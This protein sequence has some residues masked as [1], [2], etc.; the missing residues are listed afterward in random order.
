MNDVNCLMRAEKIVNMIA[1]EGK[2]KAEPELK[3]I[4]EHIVEK[5]TESGWPR[6]NREYKDE[7]SAW[8]KYL[9]LLQAAAGKE[10]NKEIE[11]AKEDAEVIF[12]QARVVEEQRVL[13][14]YGDDIFKEK[15]FEILWGVQT[16]RASA[17]IQE[18]LQQL[19]EEIKGLMDE[20]D[21]A[22]ADRDVRLLRTRQ[23]LWIRANLMLA[24]AS[25]KKENAYEP[26]KSA[27]LLKDF[28]EEIDQH[29]K[30]YNWPQGRKEPAD[31]ERELT[32]G[33]V[34]PYSGE[35][36]EAGKIRDRISQLEQEIGALRSSRGFQM[37][38]IENKDIRGAWQKIND[39]WGQDGI[40]PMS[41]E[42]PD[43]SKAIKRCW[44][45]RNGGKVFVQEDKGRSTAYE[46]FNLYSSDDNKIIYMIIDDKGEAEGKRISGRY[47]KE[48][49]KT[50]YVLSKTEME[51]RIEEYNKV[52]KILVN[53]P[54]E[55]SEIVEYVKSMVE[56]GKEDRTYEE[57]IR[58]GLESLEI[59]WGPITESD[60]K[61]KKIKPG[62]LLKDS[63]EAVA[64]IALMMKLEQNSRGDIEMTHRSLNAGVTFF[65]QQYSRDFIV[66][67]KLLLPLD[68]LKALA[69]LEKL[70][71]MKLTDGEEE[72][73]AE[74]RERIIAK[75]PDMGFKQT[76]EKTG[77]FEVWEEKNNTKNYITIRP[78]N[79]KI[80]IHDLNQRKMDFY[81]SESGHTIL[82]VQEPPGEEDWSS[83][84]VEK[85][86]L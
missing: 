53:A 74:K 25:Y 17:P 37:K 79:I 46:I 76:E 2:H 7:K 14:K 27:K 43:G 73:W 29:L 20:V 11:E 26:E 9:H 21:W 34:T 72:A 83:G 52:K 32:E 58:K 60:I 81:E 64:R 54:K 50:F 10:D 22:T 18:R 71:I 70:E 84:V 4:S 44:L 55:I 75:L 45:V 49:G 30:K 13:D 38:K 16:A 5:L 51:Q 69:G 36:A 62:D 68:K 78:N 41:E 77:E 67:N 3:K 15:T 85:S 24:A 31:K 80:T 59:L 48:K 28:A 40:I 12:E 82:E 57:K 39:W 66:K 61:D 56:Q 6:S 33:L 19:R 8:Q 65:C 35:S 1:G 47:E 63:R 23:L 86:Q 42:M